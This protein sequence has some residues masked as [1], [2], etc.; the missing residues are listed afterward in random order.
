MKIHSAQTSAYALT[1]ASRQ[2]GAAL[3]TSLLI[4]LVLSILAISS[5]Q[6]T[7]LQEKMAAAQRDGQNAL[8]LTEAAIREAEDAIDGIDL[9]NNFIAS[10]P[11]VYAAGDAPDPF[12]AATWSSAA[13]AEVPITGADF[14]DWT[15]V[16]GNNVPSPRYFIEYVGPLK[17]DS[18]TSPEVE[19][20]LQ[21]DTGAAQAQGFRIVARS[22]GLTDA[23]ERVV[24]SFFAV[25]I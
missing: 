23:T 19:G 25:K 13:S 10:R 20:N 11:E 2:R 6:G 7:A 18:V 5:M 16:Y 9:V 12:V 3:I 22:T 15:G 8:E 17:D 14:A 24:E 21:H 1:P 4:L